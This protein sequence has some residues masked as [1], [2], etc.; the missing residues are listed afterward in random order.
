M[1][2]RSNVLHGPGFCYMIFEVL[3]G[4]YGGGILILRQ[5]NLSKQC[6]LRFLCLNIKILLSGDSVKG[7]EHHAEL[8]SFNV[9]LKI[10]EN[11]ILA[12]SCQLFIFNNS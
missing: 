3:C 2:F 1:Y 8:S 11:C 10:I 6:L 5:R 9:F 4:A 12:T 7:L